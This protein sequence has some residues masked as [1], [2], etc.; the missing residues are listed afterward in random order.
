MLKQLTAIALG[1]IAITHTAHGAALSFSESADGSSITIGVND[2][3][4]GFS[5]N[6]TEIQRGLN[7]WRSTTVATSA[8]GV[9]FSG[10][11]VDLGA[12]GSG[13]RDIY[14]V[15]TNNPGIVTDVL[16]L[17]W[18]TDGSWGT[19]SGSIKSLSFGSY[20]SLP[21][22]VPSGN[23]FVAGKDSAGIFLPFLGGSASVAV[24]AVPEPGTYALAIA[25]LAVVGLT[26]RRRRAA[27]A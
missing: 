18:S 12:S 24:A 13:S 26:A 23:V 3:E 19:L 25:G 1:A 20:F 22:G 9:S 10:R 6:G 17:N 14:F 21:S 8:T 15:A 7:N 5:V 4:N 11:W 27:Q 16:S 2:F